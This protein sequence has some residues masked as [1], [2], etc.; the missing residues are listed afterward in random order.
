MC[1]G[2]QRYRVGAALQEV[3]DG[4]D[5]VLVPVGDEQTPQPA[6]VFHQIADVGND[7]VDAVHIV[8]GEGHAAVDHDDLAAV[9]IGGHVLADLVETAQRNDPQF[10][11]VNIFQKFLPPVSFPFRLFI[12]IQYHPKK[13]A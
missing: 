9:F 1:L 8:A 3:G 5:V 13:L 11:I 4:A 10:G 6:A 2:T 12:Q 7:A